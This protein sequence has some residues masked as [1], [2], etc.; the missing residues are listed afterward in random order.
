V[1][2]ETGKPIY[3]QSCGKTRGSHW[4]RPSSPQT[5]DRIAIAPNGSPGDL[6]QW[7][8][9]SLDL[10]EVSVS[11]TSRGRRLLFGNIDSFLIWNLT[12]DREDGITF[13]DVPTPAA[14]IDGLEHSAVGPAIVNDFGIPIP[15]AAE[16]CVEQ[17][18]CMELRRYLPFAGVAIAGDLVDQQASVVGQAC[19][20]P[21]EAKNILSAPVASADDTGEKPVLS[22]S[23]S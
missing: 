15:N 23:G 20:S 14:P 2:K 16:D 6:L 13:T 7:S 21:G 11:L 17:R 19:F 10:E 1:H 18:K 9:N 5:A 8:E 3:T 22:S 12:W 4:Q